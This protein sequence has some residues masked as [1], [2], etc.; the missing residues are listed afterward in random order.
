VTVDPQL[1]Q[2]LEEDPQNLALRLAA[3]FNRHRVVIIGLTRG[4][5]GE[6]ILARNMDDFQWRNMGSTGEALTQDAPTIVDSGVLETFLRTLADLPVRE[7]RT[8]Q[9]QEQQQQ[10]GQGSQGETEAASSQV[11]KVSLS[12]QPGYGDNIILTF[13]AG[14]ENLSD[15]GILVRNS[16]FVSSA[17]IE[18]GQYQK[19]LASLK[20]LIP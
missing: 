16:G 1:L 20:P 2:A 15:G 17:L 13:E 7:I 9:V 12:L 3:P 11:L 18:E 6:T 4:A 10:Q 19:L 8:L 14:A 5:N